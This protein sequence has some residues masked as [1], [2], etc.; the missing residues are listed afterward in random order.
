MK[1][2]IRCPWVAEGN[3][4][5]EIYHD[6]EWGIPVHEDRIHFEF[7]IL[8]SAQAGLNWLTILKKRYG[9]AEAF[10]YF[11]PIKVASYHEKKIQELL[12]FEGIIRNS[13]K[14]RSAVNNAQKFLKIQEEFGSFDAYIW[15]FVDHRP[16]QN[17]WTSLKDIPAETK[18]SKALSKDLKQR[19]FT[20]VGPKIMYAHMQAVGLVNDHLISCFRYHELK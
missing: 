8:E 6:K 9:Y 16:L 7:L 15:Q 2:I 14:I 13:L 1:E 5:Y 3:T 11:D 17:H 12:Q 18:E 19:G 4:L 20:F 10:S